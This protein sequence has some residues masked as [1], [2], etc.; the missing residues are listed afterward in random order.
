[1]ENDTVSLVIKTYLSTFEILI[2]LFQVIVMLSVLTGNILVLYAFTRFHH[3][4]TPTGKFI[5][6]L[7]IAD[8]CLGLSMPFQMSFFFHP[9]LNFMIGPCLLRFEVIIFT[10]TSSLLSL[11]FTVGDRYIAV[12]YPLRYQVIVSD[13]VTNILIGIVWI[14]AFVLAILPIIGYNTFD[15]AMLCAYEL[16]MT[17]SYRL[18]VALHFI[19][20]PVVM[21][22]IYSRV[23]LIAWSHKKKIFS[24][25]ATGCNSISVKIQHETRT[26]MITVVVMLIFTL[27]WLPFAVL[28]I[29]QAVEFSVSR[30]FVSNFLVFL[31]LLNSVMNP[32]IYVWKNKQYKKAFR[33]IICFCETFDQELNVNSL[34]VYPASI[35]N[36]SS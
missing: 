17:T 14:Y 20:F 21:F 13:K 9:E 7:A 5:A 6:N 22:M 28:Q 27:C 35:P 32:F 19:I 12:L 2:V 18:L 3:L 15:T 25:Q 16:V 31:G 30:A 26:A 24:E 36:N 4:Q 8:L 11:F 10:S 34:S 23:F 29:I 33:R 1:M